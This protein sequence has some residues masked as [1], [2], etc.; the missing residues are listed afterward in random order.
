MFLLVLKSTRKKLYPCARFAFFSHFR[1][2]KGICKVA[3]WIGL[4]ILVPKHPWKSK[5]GPLQPILA[6]KQYVSFFWV[7]LYISGCSA[8]SMPGWRCMA[9]GLPFPAEQACLASCI[10]P[11][12]PSWVST[13]L[14]TL[15]PRVSIISNNW[16]FI[17]LRLKFLATLVALHFTPVSKSLSQW[18]SRSFGLA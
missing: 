6:A 9:G 15:S 11:I 2:W 13:P 18:V 10:A 7:T 16:D 4:E 3:S 17:H 12:R 5:I 8:Q 1:F 14:S